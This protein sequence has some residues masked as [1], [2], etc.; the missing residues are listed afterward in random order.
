MR[1]VSK[2]VTQHE[3]RR[4]AVQKYLQ[5]LRYEL[6]RYRSVKFGFLLVLCSAVQPLFCIK[7]D[8]S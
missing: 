8:I 2:H 6:T 7:K 1:A 4:F 3:W 5:N